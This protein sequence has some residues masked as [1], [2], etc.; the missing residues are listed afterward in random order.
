[1]FVQKNKS[2]HRQPFYHNALIRRLKI[3]ITTL[4]IASGARTIDDYFMN[5]AKVAAYMGICDRLYVG[6]VIAK[7]KRV[8]ATGYNGSVSES[9]SGSDHCDEA[10]HLYND[11]LDVLVLEISRDLVT[12]F[13]Q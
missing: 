13:I 4:L 5:L 6:C 3:K 7:D 10:D 8:I 1:M 2:I 11:E 12:R 9:V